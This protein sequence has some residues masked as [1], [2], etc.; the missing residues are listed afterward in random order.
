L[1][2]SSLSDASGANLKKPAREIEGEEGEVGFL[3]L[4]RNTTVSVA[5]KAG[6]SV[7]YLSRLGADHRDSISSANTQSHR[8]S[9]T[10]EM[11]RVRRTPNKGLSWP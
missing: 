9:E 6:T 4:P 1:E 7:H 2:T 11:Y 5:Q 10:R 8:H 3:A